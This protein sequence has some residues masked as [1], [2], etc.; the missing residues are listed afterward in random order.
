MLDVVVVVV[1]I[2]GLMFSATL[3][4]NYTLFMIFSAVAV[5]SVFK[6]RLFVFIWRKHVIYPL[7]FTSLFLLLIKPFYGGVWGRGGSV[8]PHGDRVVAA[9][10][11]QQQDHP[12]QL[13]LN[14]Q[15]ILSESDIIFLWMIKT[16]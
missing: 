14:N 12:V 3:K 11:L 13:I 7:I 2:S 6:Y 8:G 4:F 9:F 15:P 1:L 16:L 10:A 5:I